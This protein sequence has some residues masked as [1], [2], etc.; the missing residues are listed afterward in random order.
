MILLAGKEFDA[1][2]NIDSIGLSLANGHTN[3][4]R[5]QTA[6]QENGAPELPCLEG[7]IPI[8]TLASAPETLRRIS[9]QEP[10]IGEEGGH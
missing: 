5:R 6:S 2:R 3:I 10:G 8:E 4:L 9:I 7:K 1:A